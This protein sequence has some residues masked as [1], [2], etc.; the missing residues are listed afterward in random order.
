MSDAPK[1]QPSGEPAGTAA[2]LRCKWCAREGPPEWSR[3]ARVWIHRRATLDKRCEAPPAPRISLA[4]FDAALV[5]RKGNNL[6]PIDL[7]A[8]LDNLNAALNAQAAAP[9]QLAHLDNTETLFRECDKA[10]TSLMNMLEEQDGDVTD[11]RELQGAVRAWL[12]APPVPPFGQLYPLAT[13][14]EAAALPRPQPSGRDTGNAQIPALRPATL[15]ALELI[16]KNAH[17]LAAVLYRK[18][19]TAEGDEAE[20]FAT[21]IELEI[22]P[23]RAASPDSGRVERLIAAGN[24]LAVA[25]THTHTSGKS[26]VTASTAEVVHFPRAIEDKNC[27]ACEALSAWRRAALAQPDPPSATTEKRRPAPNPFDQHNPQ[28]L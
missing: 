26:G 1:S 11:L 21:E 2:G 18:T 5:W 28:D 27:K 10:V 22:I 20:S 4:Q 12:A 19:L 15:T 25:L 17:D 24:A 8:T 9:P 7:P 3:D 16:A 14:V 13:G 23:A 6:K